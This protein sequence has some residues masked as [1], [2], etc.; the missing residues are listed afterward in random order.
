MQNVTYGYRCVKKKFYIYIKDE[1]K[2]LDMDQFFSTNKCE[3]ES[4]LFWVIYTSSY[5][6]SMAINIASDSRLN[7][8]SMYLLNKFSSKNCCMVNTFHDTQ[9]RWYFNLADTTKPR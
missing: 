2:Y 9:N 6:I 8:V 3:Q 5:L 7:W 4:H 1:G